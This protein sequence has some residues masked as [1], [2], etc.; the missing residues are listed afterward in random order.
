[1]TFLRSAKI[2][3]VRDVKMPQYS[4]EGAAALDFYVPNDIG[5]ESKVLRQGEVINIPSGIC[6]QLPQQ[7]ALMV[8]NKSSRGVV[9]IIKGAELIDEDYR[10]EIHLNVMNVSRE[11]V[12]IRKGEKLVQMVCVPYFKLK[13][14]E[15][16]EL[17]PSERGSGGFGST[18]LN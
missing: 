12:T 10:G 11:E 3:V 7:S 9:G 16:N 5:W 1:M 18:G 2:K 4:S 13:L 15:S 8:F 6:I 17:E 14:Y